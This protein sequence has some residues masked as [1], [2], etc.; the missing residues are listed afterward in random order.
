MVI[1]K[2]RVATKVRDTIK[3]DVPLALLC[4]LVGTLCGEVFGWGFRSFGTLILI[5]ICLLVAAYRYRL[6]Q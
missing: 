5:L 2:F 1:P 6:P 4:L 3:L